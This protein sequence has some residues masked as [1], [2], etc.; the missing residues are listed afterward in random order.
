MCAVTPATVL[1]WIRTG[2]LEG[3]RTPGGHY[4][5]KLEKLRPLLCEQ[6]TPNLRL[7][8]PSGGPPL[9]CWEYLGEWGRVREECLTCVVYRVRASWCFQIATLGI[10]SGHAR[11]VCPTSCDDCSYYRRV[12]GLPTNVLIVS[13]DPELLERL[14]G[15]EDEKIVL[16]FARN[17]YEASAAVETFLPAFAVVDL[18]T[19][20]ARENGLLESLCR[21]PRLP[22]LKTVVA[23]DRG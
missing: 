3:I 13:S 11:R 20:A 6:K 10:D 1:N 4:R 18:E 22:G 9:R 21:D 17:A 12:A 23:V 15:H 5:V 19:T 16:Q 7:E 14:G 2:R 8:R